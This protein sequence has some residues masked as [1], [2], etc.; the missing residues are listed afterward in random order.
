MA[1]ML[2]LRPFWAI[3]AH[4]LRLYLHLCLCGSVSLYTVQPRGVSYSPYMLLEYN[5]LFLIFFPNTFQGR[6]RSHYAVL[7]CEMTYIYSWIGFWEML[8]AIYDPALEDL[9]RS[10][11]L[12]PAI[13]SIN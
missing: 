13:S 9:S 4:V 2:R 12:S 8:G 5:G 6:L 3:R 1:Q 11:R 10:N 7:R